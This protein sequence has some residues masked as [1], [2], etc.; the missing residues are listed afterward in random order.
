MYIRK[1]NI[2]GVVKKR[3]ENKGNR[4]HVKSVSSRY[5]KENHLVIVIDSKTDKSSKRLMEELKKT[6]QREN[7]LLEGGVSFQINSNIRKF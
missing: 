6:I 7:R 2:A 1:Q 5:R 4:N 3:K